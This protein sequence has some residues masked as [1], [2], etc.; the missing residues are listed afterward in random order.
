MILIFYDILII[1]RQ[2]LLKIVKTS[3]T[4]FVL[5]NIWFSILSHTRRWRQQG[6]FVTVTNYMRFVCLLKIER[7][8]W[9]YC[10]KLFRPWSPGSVSLGLRLSIV[11]P[12]CGRG[13]WQRLLSCNR[14]GKK[15]RQRGKMTQQVKVIES[16]LLTPYIQK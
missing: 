10:L 4:S 5:K 16:D 13:T 9:Y 1:K 3:I 6:C 7:F 14:Q 12:Q 15:Q 2:A 11:W 8:I